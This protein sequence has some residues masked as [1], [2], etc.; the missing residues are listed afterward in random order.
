MTDAWTVGRLLE[1]TTDY[2][3]QHGADSARLDAELLLGRA[4]KCPRIALYTAWDEPVDE[5]VRTEFRE[6][7]RQRA[8]GMPVAYLLGYREF[9]SLKFRVTPDVLIPRPETEHLVVT[10]LELAKE[11]YANQ[12]EICIADVGTGSG[13]IAVCVAK[14]LPQARVTAT[15]ISAAA[16]AVASD[17]ARRHGVAE[18]V[19]TTETDLLDGVGDEGGFD[20]VLSNPPY[21]GRDEMDDLATDVRDHEPHSALFG[22]ERGT[23]VIE[24]LV[25]QAID[26]L[27]PGGFFLCEIGP[28]LDD[29]VCEM[30][31][32]QAGFELRETVKDLAGLPRIIVARKLA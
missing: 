17:N 31:G 8:E 18:R 16:L 7:V 3:N 22:G 13:V 20:F 26:R 21:I 27:K 19:V 5:A 14:H 28:R 15:D 32:Q 4:R 9:Y 29:E 12:D 2:L 25:P 6:L 1:W 10:L 23:D 30:I 24:R 11:H